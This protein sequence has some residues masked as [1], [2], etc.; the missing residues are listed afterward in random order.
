MQLAARRPDGG[1]RL[2]S[3]PELFAAWWA[4]RQGRLEFRDL[5]AYFALHEMASRRCMT[6]KKRIPR[7]TVGE[8]AQLTGTKGSR[9]IAC[10]LRRLSNVGL[11]TW[12]TNGIIFNDVSGLWIAQDETFVAGLE[13]VANRR[14]KVPVPRR[15]IRF[16]ALAKSPVIVATVLGHLLRCVYAKRTL[17]ASEGSI[18]A[19]WVA[20]VFG[21]D[22]RNVKRAKAYLRRIG[23]LL[24][25]ASDH[26]HRQRYGGRVS[27]NLAWTPRVPEARRSLPP[28]RRIKCTHLPPPDSNRELPKGIQNQKPAPSDPSGFRMR[29]AP[30]PSLQNVHPE[31]LQDTGRLMLLF[32]RAQRQRIVGN[33]EHERLQFVGAAVRASRRATNNVG[34]FFSRMIRDKLWHHLTLEEEDCAR[35]MLNNHLFPGSELPAATRN[36]R[37]A[38]QTPDADVRL[39]AHLHHSFTLHGY[40]ADPCQLLCQKD[41][42]WTRERWDRAMRVWL[43][44]QGISPEDV[45]SADPRQL[46]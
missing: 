13:R 28:R 30:T 24:P 41:P 36:V 15:T 40:D 2:I 20:G 16:L 27:V 25:A 6:A 1:Y 8:L 29:N 33:S 45:H 14:R 18:S 5:R 19:T 35:R 38:T 39:V 42:R 23:W 43:S 31:D 37:G 17:V 21:V 32:Q 22:P 3:V 12:N 4:Y 26:W 9:G 10:S 7:F 46:A 11:S 44:P 34:G